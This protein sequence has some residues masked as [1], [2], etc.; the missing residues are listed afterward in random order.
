MAGYIY[1]G[2]NRTDE[3]PT[4]PNQHQAKDGRNHLLA[5]CGTLAAYKRHKRMGEEA[6][7]PCKDA[8]AEAVAKYRGG[9]TTGKRR[10][11]HA[12]CGSYSACIRHRRKGEPVDLA[13]RLAESRYRAELK[14][15]KEAA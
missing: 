13:C 4:P 14:A 6:C 9:T 15:R 12:E 11:R 10:P 7:D 5:P 2:T 3:D 8:N 1:R